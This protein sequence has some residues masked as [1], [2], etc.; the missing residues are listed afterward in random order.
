MSLLDSVKDTVGIGDSGGESEVDVGD[1]D[2]VIPGDSEGPPSDDGVSSEVEEDE[3]DEVMEW[4][5]AYDFAEWWLED[6]GFADLTEFGEKAMMERM[7]GS[8]MFRDRIES[9][10]STLNSINEAKTTLD[11]IAG[12]DT[13]ERDIEDMAERLKAANEVID[14]TKS[15][16]G[17]D[18]M[19]MRQGMELAR[20]AVE[21]IGGSVNVGSNNVNARMEQTEERI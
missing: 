11:D 18:E 17:E 10:L 1:I 4:D 15:L 16:N 8:P 2:D 19:M 6:E 20:D 7:E 9:G 21:A 3:E 5:S 14:A 13:Q 12:S